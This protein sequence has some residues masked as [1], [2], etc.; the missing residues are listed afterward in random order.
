MLS[1]DELLGLQREVDRVYVDPALHRVRG[2]PGDRDARAAGPRDA[3]ARALHHLRRQPARLDQPD[4][5]RPRPGLRPRPRLRPAPGRPRHGPRRDAPPPRPVVRGALRQRHRR[6]DP[7][8]R[9]SAASRS[10]SS[11]SGSSPT[12]AST[13]ER[14]LQRLD[15]QVIRR[16]DGLLQGDYRS[17]F[18]G[19]GVDLADLREYQPGDDVRY[20]DWN[21]TA[22]MDTPYVR[23]Y[24]EDR[25]ITA[26][27]LLDLSPSVDFGTVDDGPPEADRPD[28]LRDDARPAADPA[29]QPGRRHLLRQQG[30]AHDPG[31]R[32]PRPGAA[33]RPGP[34][35]PAAPRAA[36]RSPTCAAARGRA[37]A[38]SSAARSSSSSRTSSASPAGSGR[39][40]C[41]SR[42]H[43]VLAVRL[44]DPREIGPARRRPDHHGGRRDRRAAL[45]GHR[46]DGGSGAASQEAAATREAAV[47]RRLPAGRRRGRLALDRRG[48]R[49][50]RSSGWRRSAG[51][52]GPDDVLHLAADAP[53]RRARPP[54]RPAV[55]RPRRTAPAGADR[56]RP[57][58]RPGHGPRGRSACAAADPGRRCS[59]SGSRS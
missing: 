23:E 42:R 33:P 18:H 20:I 32:R 3:R 19:N 44:I 4:P 5:H 14:I 54:R 35:R 2:P 59:C 31:P 43:E 40:T 37:P 53:R 49:R 15:W 39:S 56:R 22:R 16:L 46:D 1:T 38:R 25:E 29:R 36:R 50:G 26:W 58:P 41:S 13:P 27:F 6:R 57:R 55:P 9:S 28:R 21:V 48:P 10:R 17:L 12:S 24:H 47:E 8:R 7:A 51:G 11:P 45:R 34:A 52:G 30:R